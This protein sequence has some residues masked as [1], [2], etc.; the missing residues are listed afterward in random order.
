MNR[1][2]ESKEDDNLPFWCKNNLTFNNLACNELGFFM[3]NN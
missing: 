3:Q 2:V 1:S